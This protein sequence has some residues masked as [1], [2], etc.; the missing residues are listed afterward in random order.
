VTGGKA[1]RARG[2]RFEHVVT[3]RL[4]ALGFYVCRSAGSLG[5]ADLVALRGDSL[6]LLINCKITDNTTTRIRRE[7]ANIA[8]DAGALAIIATKPNRGKIS[9]QRIDAD[10]TRTAYDVGGL[11]WPTQL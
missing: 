5:P 7:L 4:R 10:G 8:N 9:W 2:D 11:I 3:A 1:P 6:P